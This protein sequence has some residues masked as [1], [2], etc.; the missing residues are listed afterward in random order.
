M[1]IVMINGSYRS[2]GVT[3][4]VLATMTQYLTERDIAVEQVVLRERTLHYCQNCRGCMQVEQ[5]SFGHC[6]QQDDM[7]GILA[8]IEQSD[9]LI[10]ASP[11]NMG[12]VTALYKCFMERLAVYGY[13]PFGQHAPKYRHGRVYRKRAILIDSCAAPGWMARWHFDTQKTLANSAQLMGA[14]VVG[15]MTVGLQSQPVPLTLAPKWV[16]QSQ[17]V[18]VR[19]LASN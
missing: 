5:G 6:H 18:L 1:S 12:T 4:Q 2:N 16:D 9:R 14:R 17:R 3:D 8:L 7:A 15:R 11:T 13:W 10:L 19:L